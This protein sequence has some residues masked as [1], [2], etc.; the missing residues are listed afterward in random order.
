MNRFKKNRLPIRCS[1]G[2]FPALKGFQ[3]DG[4]RNF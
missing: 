1:S 4:I 3:N 2:K